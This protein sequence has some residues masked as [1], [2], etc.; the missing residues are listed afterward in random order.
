MFFIYRTRPLK[1]REGEDFRTLPEELRIES[2]GALDA[3]VRDIY[4]R[5][6]L[7]RNVLQDVEEDFPRDYVGSVKF[8][9]EPASVSDYL[10]KLIGFDINEF[11]TLCSKSEEAFS[12]L[13]KLIEEMGTFVLLIG[14]LGSHHTNIPVEVFRGF[15]VV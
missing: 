6:D 14:N 11:E 2:K 15:C 4:V 9:L 1:Q 5:Q 13:R 7:V 3:L 10:G 8:D 12:Y